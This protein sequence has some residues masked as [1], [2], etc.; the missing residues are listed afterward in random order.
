MGRWSSISPACLARHLIYRLAAHRVHSEGPTGHEPIRPLPR[1]PAC[2]SNATGKRVVVS[3]TKTEESCHMFR[4]IALSV[5]FAVCLALLACEQGSD[6]RW[7]E[8]VKSQDGRVIS[9]S[10]RSEFKAPHGIGQAAGESHMWMEFEHPIT[11]ETVRFESDLL[12]KSD[13]Q[14]AAVANGASDPSLLHYPY[15]LMLVGDDVYVVTKLYSDVYR[16]Y[17]CPDPPF[18][19]YRW[20]KGRWERRPF[21]EIPYRKF[22][23]NLTVDP[24]SDLQKI[25]SSGRHLK[26]EQVVF[27][28]AGYGPVEFDF[29]G[30]TRQTFEL[31]PNCASCTVTVKLGRRA[32]SPVAGP[33]CTRRQRDWK[34]RTHLTN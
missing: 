12:G 27:T 7:K 15:V 25:E 18:L 26:A 5:G 13:E 4:A 10:R 14:V 29:T 28:E 31:T 33:F 19:L 1:L 32:D 16:F 11:K 8:D 24:G 23:P 21:E 3:Q 2:G 20:Q 6:L 30:M 34:A 22:A 9:V 17:G